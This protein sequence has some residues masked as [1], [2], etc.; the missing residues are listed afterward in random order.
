[1]HQM[2][3]GVERAVVAT[4]GW[5]KQLGSD[6]IRLSHFILAL[7]EEEEGRPA[8]LLERAGL[9]V[10]DVRNRLTA[11]I[12]CPAA[13][14]DNV[15]FNA[16]RNWSLLHR[17]DPEFLTDA[18]LLATLR[19]SSSFETMV[20]LDAGRLEQLLT[21]TGRQDH[22]QPQAA[23]EEESL[24]FFPP[25]D[26]TNE[27][28]AARVLDAGF[29]RAREA[30]RVIE[31]FCRFVKDDR[32]LTEQA[33]EMRHA[34]AVVAAKLPPRLLATA[35]E[36]LTDVGTSLSAPGEYERRTPHDVAVV[37]GKRLQETLRSLEEFGKLFAPDLGRDLE[38]LRYRAY[39]LEKALNG[40]AR[41]AE[42]L[43]GARLYL[44]LT[45]SQC[46]A[47][48]DWTIERAAAGGV[49]I[50][51]LRE[52]DLPDRELLARARDVRRWT[53]QAGVL[54]VMNDR[55]DIARLAEADGVHLGQ[56]DLS[57]KDA[58][59]IVGLEALVG[60][61][62]HNLEQ[63]RQAVLEGADYLGIGPVFPSRTKEFSDFPGLE[64]VAKAAAETSLP[65]FALGGV[66]PANIAAVVQAGASRVA[67]G[68]AIAT[69][70]DPEQA[71][72]LLASALMLA[73]NNGVREP[74][75]GK[76]QRMGSRDEGDGFLPLDSRDG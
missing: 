5:A 34:L 38:T 23:Q 75:T 76:C 31:D 65:A 58:R 24:V 28:E 47:S 56:D 43:A 30:I 32:F 45:G 46:A 21:G 8:V 2:S 35:R 6:V 29:N 71:S 13:P 44:L 39:T 26:A 64:F 63:V 50:V 62:T 1:M 69:A 54:F 40:G 48:L 61:S 37:N 15:L 72:R 51:Q 57:I 16:A 60:R 74:A 4:R 59:R 73:G 9:S 12:D 33:K 11:W 10:P 55:P 3:P 70:D 25:P 52:K 53:R 7:L 66:G 18:L 14:P 42:K 68:A 27:I 20:G 36:T 67:V 49:N 41:N 17:H 22:S 19:A